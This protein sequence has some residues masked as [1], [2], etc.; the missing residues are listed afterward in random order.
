MNPIDKLLPLLDKVKSRGDKHIACCPAH[1]DKNPSLAIRELPDG[2]VILK[3][4]AGCS[5]ESI[6][7]SLGLTMSDLFP[8]SNEPYK[9]N[10]SEQIEHEKLTAG[11]IRADIEN[12]LPLT[13]ETRDRLEL[14]LHRLEAMG[15]KI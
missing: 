5:A 3:C 1:P 15:C 12:G 6:V 4:W 2:K 13:K 11:I 14:A 7:M 9:R 10:Y 8:P